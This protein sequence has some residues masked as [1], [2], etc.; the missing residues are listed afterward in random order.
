LNQVQEFNIRNKIVG[1]VVPK[2]YIKPVE[3]GMR[4]AAQSGILAGYPVID[5]KV[6]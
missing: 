4:E 1:G 6:H 3:D 2:E 5:F